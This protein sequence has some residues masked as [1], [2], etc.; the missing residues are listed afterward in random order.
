MNGAEKPC[1]L[2][3]EDEPEVLRINARILRRRGYE[4]YEASGCAEA[5]AVLDGIM[6]DLLILDIMLPD[7]SGYDICRRFREKSDHPIIFLTGKN[8]T[9]DRIEGLITGADYYITKPYEPDE[10]IAV[11]GRLIERHLSTQGKHKELTAITKGALTVDIPRARATVNGEDVGLTS[12]E[13][14]LLLTLVQ[15]EDRE[16]SPRD[17]YE[18]VWGVTSAD[19]VR[20]V[21]THIKNLRRKIG[22]DDAADYD[23]VSAYGK[24]YTFT[25][26]R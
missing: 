24:G 10:L 12:K 4:V 3:V 21:R 6:P 15:N 17:L 26:V 2:T 7:G 14:A 22:A 1:I 13:F 19:D 18:A 8:A 16:V 20:T 11:A 25:T 5:Y 9:A 23:I